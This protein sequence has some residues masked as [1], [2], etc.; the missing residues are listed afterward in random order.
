MEQ[1]DP[2]RHE[3]W[4]AIYYFYPDNVMDLHAEV[5]RQAFQVSELRV[6]FYGMKEF[7][8]RDPDGHILWFWQ[9]TD[10]PPTPESQYA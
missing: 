8:V 2:S 9:E 3:G 7:E 6:T 4:P 1:I 10:E 5:K